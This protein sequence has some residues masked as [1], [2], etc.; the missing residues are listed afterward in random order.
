MTASV[1]PDG[2]RPRGRLGYRPSGRLT[3]F[4]LLVAPA[5]MTIVGLLTI[6]LAPRSDL[7]WSWGDLWVSLVYAGMIAGI[8]LAFSLFRFRAD[9]LILPIVATLAGLGLLVIQRLQ[10]DLAALDDNLA[11]LASRQIIYMT[12]GLVFMVALALFPPLLPLLRRYKYTALVLSLALL[13][14]TFVFGVEVGGARLWLYLGPIQ[15]Q[16]SEIVKVTLIVFLAGYL[17]EKRDLLTGGWQIGAVTLPP[18]PWLLPL[19]LMWGASIATVIVLNDLGSGLL[20]FSIFLVMLYAATGRG[21][22]VI[23]GLA[24]F[25]VACVVL[26]QFFGRIAIRVQ[27]WLDPFVDPYGGGYQQVQSDYAISS[28]GLFGTGLGLGQPWFVSQVHTDYVFAAYGE[29]LGLLGTLAIVALYLFLVLRAFIIALNADDTFDRLVAIGIGAT[30]GVQT[31]IILGGVVRL[32]PLTG[33]TLPF[34]SYG[35]SS[36]L[37]NFV[38]IGLL[39][40]ISNR[41]NR[42]PRT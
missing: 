39:L 21:W 6:Y 15:I 27:N 17:D 38:L 37:T 32:I 14:V 20:F 31:L 3:E 1:Q 33:I 34:V 29:E 5:L 35:G 16:P 36:L 41:S 13:A 42:R 11:G 40:N 26:Y 2:T 8:S 24:S 30:I 23:V 12:A 22:Y 4:Q 9:Q 19:G 10:P 25:A 28:G 18:L 7:L